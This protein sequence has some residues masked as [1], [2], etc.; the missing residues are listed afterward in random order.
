MEEVERKEGGTIKNE[1]LK[2]ETNKPKLKTLPDPDLF[3]TEK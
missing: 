3:K 1:T 2:M